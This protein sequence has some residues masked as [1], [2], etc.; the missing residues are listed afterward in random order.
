MLEKLQKNKNIIKK[1]RAITLIT[2][3][4]T[5]ILL[6]ILAG[7]AI[8][9]AVGQNGLFKRAKEA[10]LSM[11]EATVKE[12]IQNIIL[13]MQIDELEKG[14]NLSLNQVAE[15][16]IIKDS[17]ITLEEYTE[18]EKELKGTYNLNGEEYKF[19]INEKL[20]VEIIGKAE[21]KKVSIQEITWQNGKA[22]VTLTSKEQGTIEYKDSDGTWKTF[23]NETKLENGTTLT[24]RVKLPTGETTKEEQIEIRDKIKPTEF[25]IEVAINQIQAKAV[26]I[27]LKTEPQDNETGL[28]EGYTYIAQTN[29]S[30][31]E[32]TNITGTTYK[33]T[34]LEPETNYTVY[35]IAY[36][37]AG[38]YRESNKIKITTLAYV[39]PTPSA[40]NNGT[41]IRQGNKLPFTWAQL[42]EISTTIENTLKDDNPN[43]DIT[44]NTNE[45]TLNYEGENYTIGVGDWTT[46]NYNG[47]NLKVRIMG[48]NHDILAGQDI[49][50]ENGTVKDEY[51]NTTNSNNQ[52]SEEGYNRLNKAGISF[53]F[54]D[55]IMNSNMYAVNSTENNTIGGWGNRQI[56]RTLNGEGESET[57]LNGTI[58]LLLDIKQYKKKVTKAYGATYNNSILSYT[59]DELWLLS[60]MEIYGTNNSGY[61]GSVSGYSK[62]IE[63]RQYKIYRN[64]NPLFDGLTKYEQLK[65]TGSRPWSLRSLRADSYYTICCV[66]GMGVGKASEG[67]MATYGIAPGFSI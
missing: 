55:C 28:K 19:I 10:K 43:N 35:V 51:R 63:G 57:K 41:T 54:V 11:Q 7:V 1:E 8:N 30:K 21:E 23:D 59:E 24:V 65:K 34:E 62:S 29:G 56:R 52:I 13:E 17:N 46:V 9:L 39:P 31:I 60:C 53:E 45:F 18:G 44:N 40:P 48:F 3:V 2:L 50:N 42:S 64:V 26:T 49:L 4:I 16:L 5:I 37:N 33:L 38:N 20:E 22:Q 12:I 6:I 25:E 47:N 61:S 15:N 66:D 14:G 27:T 36:D 67:A 58:D 32:K